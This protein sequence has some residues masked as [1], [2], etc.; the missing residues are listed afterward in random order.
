MSDNARVTLLFFSHILL[1]FLIGLVNNTL[2]GWSL[3]LH[4]DALLLVFFGLF[5]NR[6][7]GLV[8][9]ALLGF[10]TDALHPVP[11]GTYLIGYVLLWAFFVLSQRRIRR[12]NPL[13]VRTI[14][15][16]AQALWLAGLAFFLGKGLW[17]EWVYWQRVLVDFL[18]SALV[19]FL[20]AWPWC[21]L[22]KKLLY[23]LGWDLD[24]QLTRM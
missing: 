24:A 10:M 18:A 22:Q 5:L 4:L 8:F 21:L 1:Y 19:L 7:K 16:V 11:H 15:V 9:S 13:H 17:T 2:G 20:A 3:H 12:Q 23:S 6:M 14:A